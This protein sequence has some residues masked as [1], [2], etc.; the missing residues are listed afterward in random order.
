M[1]AKR[2]IGP[3]P[4]LVHGG[5]RDLLFGRFVDARLFDDLAL[6]RR[7]IRSAMISGG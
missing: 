5:V 6:A 3:R 1:L 7:Q 4:N 2:I